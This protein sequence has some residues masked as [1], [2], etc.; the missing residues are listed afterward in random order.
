MQDNISYRRPGTAGLLTGLVTLGCALVCVGITMSFIA[1]LEGASF[2][3]TTCL[4]L[5]S[6]DFII[7]VGI[8]MLMGGIGAHYHSRYSTR[9]LLTPIFVVIMCFCAFYALGEI[10]LGQPQADTLSDIDRVVR[11]EGFA[12]SR[13]FAKS[14]GFLIVI[15]FPV[16]F[17]TVLLDLIFLPIV[18]LFSTTIHLACAKLII[19]TAALLTCSSVPSIYISKRILN[20]QT[21][22]ANLYDDDWDETA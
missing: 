19:Y 3:V 12:I 20:R 9:Q 11:Y 14:A 2:N 13:G 7:S 10:I 22:Y 15:L 6:I 21:L 17:V 5:L 18:L 4:S 1:L 16:L 8:S